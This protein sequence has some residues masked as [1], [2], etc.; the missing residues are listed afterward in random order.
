MAKRLSEF[1]DPRTLDPS[2]DDIAQA[3]KRPVE[4]VSVPTDKDW[5][6]GTMFYAVVEGEGGIFG[7]YRALACWVEAIIQMLTSCNDW[8]TLEAMIAAT[9]AELERYPYCE[10]DKQQLRQVLAVATVRL[11]ELKA[12]AA[13]LIRAWNWARGWAP[14]LKACPNETS[15]N[16]ALQLYKTQKPQFSV[17]TDAIAWVVQIARQHREYL[18]G[19][20][21]VR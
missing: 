12:Q 7:S 13:G 14:I 4:T 1:L 2:L 5:K 21:V 16:I 8:Q 10:A 19:C 17:F 6:W 15:L 18:R 9:V 3:V 20:N 11:E